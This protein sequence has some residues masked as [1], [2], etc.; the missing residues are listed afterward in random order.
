MQ[1]RSSRYAAPGLFL[2]TPAPSIMPVSSLERRFGVNVN[3]LFPVYAAS[4]AAR[5][6]E[7]CHCAPEAVFTPSAFISSAIA[8]KLLPA[9]LCDCR[10]STTFVGW[11]VSAAVTVP[12]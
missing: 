1:S 9:D 10:I 11:A 7:G 4:S 12:A 3:D 5:T 8:R 2:C 6:L